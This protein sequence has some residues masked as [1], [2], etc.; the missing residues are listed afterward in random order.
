MLYLVGVLFGKI[1]SCY[2]LYE[3][4]YLFCRY[5]AE[6]LVGPDGSEIARRNRKAPQFM[7]CAQINGKEFFRNGNGMGQ[8]LPYPTIIWGWTSLNIH[9]TSHNS[10]T[11]SQ[12]DFSRFGSIDPWGLNIR[13]FASWTGRATTRSCPKPEWKSSLT[14]SGCGLAIQCHFGSMMS[15]FLDRSNIPR[16]NFKEVLKWGFSGIYFVSFR[17]TRVYKGHSVCFFHGDSDV[18]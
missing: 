14:R 4:V 6:S 11:F 8:C 9:P 3:K 16:C 15:L 1:L 10:M 17:G 12:Q 18:L 5:G 2:T 13:P 7:P